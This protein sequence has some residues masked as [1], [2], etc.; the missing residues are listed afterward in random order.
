M[1]KILIISDTH[2]PKKGTAF[3]EP[4]LDILSK[5]IDYIFHAGDWTAKSVYE[6]LKTFAPVYAVRGN[7]DQDSWSSTLPDKV[8]VDIE[9][10]KV[11]MVH[12]H[13][14]KGRSTPERAYRECQRD[15]ADLIIFGHSHIPFHDEK[16]DS[17]LFNP[18]S[19]TDKRR[20]KQFSFGIA[21]IDQSTIILTHHYFS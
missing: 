13:L 20:Q 8:L 16:G 7:V 2:M 18:G 14:G 12:G 1:K 5:H 3:P 19:P 21:E 10:V 11:A 15:G 4:I 9:N 17:I 6:E